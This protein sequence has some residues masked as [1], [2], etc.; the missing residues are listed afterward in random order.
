MDNQSAAE[1]LQ[2][3]RTLMERSALYRRALAPIMLLTGAIGTA[4]AIVG[5]AMRVESMHPFCRFWLAV[6]IVAMTGTLAIARRQSLK[7][8]EPVLSPPA[9]RVVL[10]LFPT[11]LLGGS[12]GLGMFELSNDEA[13]QFLM[14][15]VI[16]IA[17]YG[18]ALN[19]A[20]HFTTRGLRWFGLTFALPACA[21][22]PF[23]MRPAFDPPWHL[24]HLIM[25]VWFG[26]FHLLFGAYL[27]VTEKKETSA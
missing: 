17:L 4:G 24:P 11:L 10:A 9:R 20:G 5:M 15:P 22:L 1:N 2:L 12:L 6:G 25:G 23:S 3:I 8:R 14:V 18:C 16:W 26:L 19:A 21:V 27:F 13:R 7:T